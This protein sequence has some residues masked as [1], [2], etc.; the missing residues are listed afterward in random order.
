MNTELLQENRSLGFANAESA[1]PHFA[2]RIIE[3]RRALLEKRAVPEPSAE[4]RAAAQLAY[5]PP[6]VRKVNPHSRAPLSTSELLRIALRQAKQINKDYGRDPEAELIHAI[7]ENRVDDAFAA[8]RA[9]RDPF[10]RSSDGG[11]VSDPQQ[12][13]RCSSLTS[14]REDHEYGARAHANI[15]RKICDRR[16]D[17]WAA[18]ADAQFAASEAHRAAAADPTPENCGKAV[19]AC[20]RCA[21]TTGEDDE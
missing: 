4:Y 19:V 18:R 8:V 12:L 21:A 13:M 20:Q 17:N 6:T 1:P 7:R 16:K 14:D 9:G 10:A 3:I 5:R 2:A 11:A 15:A